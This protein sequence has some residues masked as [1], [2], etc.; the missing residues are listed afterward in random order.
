M[1]KP[2]GKRTKLIGTLKQ[3]RAVQFMAENGGVVSTAMLKAGYSPVTAKV[4]GKLTKS[5]TF[6]QLLDQYLPEDKLLQVGQEGLA[7]TKVVTSHTEPDSEVPD[8][9]VRHKYYETGLKLRGKLRNE[10]APQTQV[11]VPIIIKRYDGN[12]PKTIDAT[13]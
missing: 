1:P 8:F 13:A 7:A 3:R 12:E 5:P 9:A 11:I 10:D 2:E 4:P 6:Q